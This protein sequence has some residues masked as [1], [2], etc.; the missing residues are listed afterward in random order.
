MFHERSF[1][2]LSINLLSIWFVLDCKDSPVWVWNG[3]RNGSIN[4]DSPKS[5]KSFE[6]LEEVERQLNLSSRSSES[7]EPVPHLSLKS[8]EEITH[9][10]TTI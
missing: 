3:K 8:S 1:S 2:R 10:E 7:A 4:S 9:Y 5:R 6:H